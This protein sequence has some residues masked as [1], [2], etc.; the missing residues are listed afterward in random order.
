YALG[1]ASA[2]SN[3][4]TWT[5][6]GTDTAVILTN[7][8]LDEDTTYYL[9]ARATDA[10]G[11]LSDILTG[12]GI[13]IDLTAPSGTTVNDGTGEDI[14]Y[15]GS[16]TTL[17]ANWPAF[18]EDVSG[19]SHYEIGVDD[20]DGDYISWTSIGD[21]TT[22]T[23]TGLNLTNGTLYY[24][25]VLA[26]D[27]AGNLSDVVS[28]DG[29]TVD[30]EGPFAGTVFDGPDADMD[31]T[32]SSTTL[33]A[34]WK[35]FSDPLSGIQYYEYAIGT[36]IDSVALVDWTSAG[37][38]TFFTETDLTLISSETYYVRVKATDNVNN[39][40]SV[41]VSDGIMV[42]LII[43]LVG[44]LYDGIDGEDQDWQSSDSTFSLYWSGSDSRELNYY[45]YSVGTSLGDSNTVSWTSVST[46]TSVTLE[47]V[48][49][50]EEQT[51]YGNVRAVDRAG[52]VSD[53]VSSDGISID[54]TP[55]A[56]GTVYDGLYEDI[57]YTGTADSLTAHCSGFNDS[58]SGI[59]YFEYAIG[60]TPQGSDIV[61]WTLNNTDTTMIH[62]GLSLTNGTPYYFSVRATD[63]AV[64]VSSVASSDGVTVDIENPVSG[65]VYDGAGEDESWTNSFTT[66]EGNWSG[67]SD[68]VSGLQYY[69][70]AIGDS[71]ED[72]NTVDWMNNELETTFIRDDL[73][74][75]SGSMYYIS[76]R[77]TD[78]VENTSAVAT[79][80]GITVDQFSPTVSDPFDGSLSEDIDWQQDNSMLI[81]AWQGNDTREIAYYEYS[82]GTAQGD[83]NVV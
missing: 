49:L 5:S 46:N 72:S 30:I 48:E 62:I 25:K 15:T 14:S 68:A 54:Y 43:P 29:V 71:P 70:Y 20:G 33:E 19:V 79:S 65:V 47:N 66:L 40:G 42:D 81:A 45:Q 74:L 53:V 18:T 22:H 28:G 58:F 52:N 73:T 37:S 82:F 26:M 34:N 32:N 38:D 17:S 77:A 44:E 67:F 55:P 27:V 6:S 41:A 10:A 9:S 59:Q 76:V 7:L 31:W 1:T 4:V 8:T 39:E 80:N 56:I 35:D 36:E 21:T 12:D 63:F 2:D 57:V 11:N 3:T 60:S 50:L 23:F 16:D 83:S 61:D 64:N 78:L 51:Y 75:Q 24:V 69:E 13:T